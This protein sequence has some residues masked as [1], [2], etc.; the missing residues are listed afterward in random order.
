MNQAIS[1]LSPYFGTGT[2]RD[3][4][5]RLDMVNTTINRSNPS[6]ASTGAT[7]PPTPRVSAVTATRPEDRVRSQNDPEQRVMEAL[8][9]DSLG[10]RTIP[11]LVRYLNEILTTEA[12]ELNSKFTESVDIYY[13]NSSENHFIKGNVLDMF[14]TPIQTGPVTGRRAGRQQ[15]NAMS[16]AT[17]GEGA[18]VPIGYSAKELINAPGSERHLSAFLINTARV[19]FTQRNNNIIGLFANS[20]PNIEINRISPYLEV[21]FNTPRTP[22]TTRDNKEVINGMSLVKFINGAASIEKNSVTRALVMA[23]KT[24]RPTT[25][26]GSAGRAN[27]TTTSTSAITPE[28]YTSAGME[29]FTS[30][31]SL[32]N[33][34]YTDNPTLHS[35]K[36][37]DKFLPF[38]SLEGVEL[39]VVP[40]RGLMSNKTGTIK[41]KLHDR[42]R[43]ADIA[44]F[45]R[46][47]YYGANEVVL[48]YGWF[49]PDGEK[50]TIG[51]S[52]DR[53]FYGDLLNGMRVQ[54]KYQIVNASYSM[55]ENGEVTLELRVSMK[56]ANDFETESIL[57][58]DENISNSMRAIQ[59]LQSTIVDLRRAVFGDNN[60]SFG[61]REIR[62]TQILDAAGDGVNHLLL[63]RELRTSLEQMR[64]FLGNVRRT[65]QRG[66]DVSQ[67][68]TALNN[69]ETNVRSAQTSLA[70]MLR[71]KLQILTNS[72]DPIKDGALVKLGI[73]I[74]NTLDDR[75]VVNGTQTNFNNF[76]Q[77]I[78]YTANDR[79]NGSFSLAKLLLLFVGIPLIQTD[80]YHDV[81]FYFY[82]FNVNAAQANRINTGEFVI[83]ADLFMLKFM[84]WRLGSLGQSSNVNLREFIQWLAATFFDDPVSEVYGLKTQTNHGRSAPLYRRV[85]TEENGVGVEPNIAA[86]REARGTTGVSDREANF[87]QALNDTLTNLTPN[88][89]FRVPQIEFYIESLPAKDP[90]NQD[91]DDTKTVLKIHVFDRLNSPYESV[92]QINRSTR[93]NVI[94]SIGTAVTT[95]NA[96][97]AQQEITTEANNGR[98]LTAQQIQQNTTR[99][100]TLDISMAQ[101]NENI[102]RAV[103]AEIL[104]LIPNSNPVRYRLK[105]GPNSARN[106]KEFFY[107]VAPYMIYGSAGSI[108]KN[109]SLSSLQDSRLTTVNFLRS[110]T[111]SPLEPNG[112]NP[113]GL[114]MQVIPA[115][116]E[117]EMLGCPFFN[118]G[119]TFF[120]DFNTGTTIDNFYSVVGA[121]YSI[122]PGS[123][124]TRVKMAPTDGYG[125]YIN[126]MNQINNFRGE[127]NGIQTDQEAQAAVVA[128]KEAGRNTTGS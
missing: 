78:G 105:G 88:G 76:L 80:K 49:H 38:M 8:L 90:T 104:E 20:I 45:I 123:F 17:V 47:E 74:D 73:S 39:N 42:S 51:N 79:V 124:D 11:D 1:K 5:S 82:P 119:Q 70:S 57:T 120:M 15:T 97:Q 21:R 59:E 85:F 29:M 32:V 89:E 117:L 6:V 112:E 103:A 65:G 23:N 10:A 63:T 62:G 60:S 13:A 101:Y 118:V 50:L 94:S 35:Q 72:P 18:A 3:L 122:G 114:P 44:E 4:I 9:D 110:H 96:A 75:I 12:T 28:F 121:T 37:L 22:T 61:S 43:L 111:A 64:R 46:P 100:N 77:S 116:L 58:D 92:Q 127:L 54:E 56:G 95:H 87:M 30:P 106:L 53:N 69:Y 36:I 99:R 81:Q 31:Q 14:D 107:T 68:V 40:T 98:R 7:N 84:Q 67:L 48:E 86:G 128:A 71:K 113:G 108:I 27:P 34:N 93:D 91:I 26:A 109:A 24:D 2:T 102:Q 125:Q 115:Q 126:I 55:T 16:K 19:S 25:G 41:I 52:T 83:N 33:G 66:N